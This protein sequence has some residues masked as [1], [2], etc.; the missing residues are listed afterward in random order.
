ME[1]KAMN[2]RRN[3]IV[4]WMLNQGSSIVRRSGKRGNIYTDGWICLV[5]V[6]SMR[7]L[8]AYGQAGAVLLVLRTEGEVP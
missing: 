3:K 1:G 2:E 4:Q 5:D 8:A 6:Q 7:Q